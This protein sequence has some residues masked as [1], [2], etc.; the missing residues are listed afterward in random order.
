MFDGGSPDCPLL[1]RVLVDFLL[2]ALP[3]SSTS[4][5]Q[6]SLPSSIILQLIT[7]TSIT[8]IITSTL[9]HHQTHF[10]DS[11]GLPF[12]A[13]SFS[14]ILNLSLFFGLLSS[15]SPSTYPSVTSSSLNPGRS[16]DPM[17]ML[18]RG[19]GSRWAGFS[20]SSRP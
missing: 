8:T 17:F 4:N 15:S 10:L 1:A 19:C 14:A 18:L 3:T 13:T 20:S 5:L 6:R 7:I 2:M 9:H 12:A 11:L 16:R